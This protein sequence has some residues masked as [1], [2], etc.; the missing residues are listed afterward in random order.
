MGGLKSTLGILALENKKLEK[1]VQLKFYTS[2]RKCRIISW[3]YEFFLKLLNNRNNN[4]K[5]PDHVYSN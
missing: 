3:P 4:T 1:K 5:E 2:I